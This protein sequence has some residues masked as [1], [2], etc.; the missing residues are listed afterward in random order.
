MNKEEIKN[1]LRDN[2]IQLYK[3]KVIRQVVEFFEGEG[4]VLALLSHYPQGVSPSFIS[5]KLYISRARVTNILNALRNKNYVTMKVNE[6]DRR[7]MFV[8][9]TEDSRQMIQHR[10][11]ENE[12][13]FDIIYEKVGE[14]DL[15]KLIETIQNAIYAFNK[16]EMEAMK[17][18]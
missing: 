2:L 8:V 1:S 10:I 11:R 4:A 17:N 13:F 7:K 6:K 9:L 5:D 14:E 12:L 18:E 15:I 16:V 3:T